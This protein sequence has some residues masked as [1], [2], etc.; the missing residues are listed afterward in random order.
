MTTQNSASN[1]IPVATSALLLDHDA[2]TRALI[3]E[4]LREL[5]WQAAATDS[6]FKA[7]ELLEHGKVDILIADL[8]A[9][10]PDSMELVR[11]ALHENPGLDAVLIVAA[12]NA[13]K[14]EE[15]VRLRVSDY[16]VRP[17]D[18]VAVKRVLTRLAEKHTGADRKPAL[19]PE[20]ER[21]LATMVGDSEP[22]RK[23]RENVLIAA[24]AAKRFPV[25]VMGES[26]TGKEL[27][28]RAIHACSGWRNQPFIPVDCA[29]LSPTLIESELFGHAKEAFTGANHARV[30]LLASAGS[31]TVF[32]DEIGL[33]PLEH[34][35]RLLRLFQE[36]EI[37]PLGSN[38][39]MKVEARLIAATNIDLEK[40]VLDGK[41]REDL[42]FRLKVF[43]I[44]MPPLRE[45]KSDILPLVH[46]FLARSG[47]DEGI[48]DFSPAFMNLL[49]KYHWPGNV[50]ELEHAV[51]H[52]VA[53]CLGGAKL[54]VKD[55]PSTLIYHGERSSGTRD[56]SRLQALE[57]DAIIEV[58]RWTKGD[59]VRAAKML[60]IGKTT[61]Y[62]KVKEYHLDDEG[63]N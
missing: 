47:A 5:G 46:H 45:R 11:R 54:D 36:H 13:A 22:M 57:R 37:R 29:S 60:G 4:S 31:G 35:A 20:V 58:L 6:G 27:A 50:R 48:A 59:R 9:P 1:G 55:L 56:V 16:L 21:A 14:A 3:D 63:L 52:A 2:G 8:D 7:V 18:A 62:R 53:H 12:E 39:T 25:L 61:I 30:G 51:D 42:Y 40:A 15:G 24:T 17:F 10:G 26:G 28:A 44:H 49:M 23:V 43:K 19:A 38:E 32:F 41:F 34:Q 33:L